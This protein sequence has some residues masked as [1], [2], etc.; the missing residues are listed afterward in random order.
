MSDCRSSVTC[1]LGLFSGSNNDKLEVKLLFYG[2]VASR[3][4]EKNIFV[5]D[6]LISSFKAGSPEN[7]ALSRKQLYLVTKKT[8][9]EKAVDQNNV[10]H[11]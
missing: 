9:V 11:S 10:T 7:L 6:F 2:Q 4:M 3:A 5:W 8:F 1:S